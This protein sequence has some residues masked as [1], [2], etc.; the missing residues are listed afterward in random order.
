MHQDN[1]YDAYGA[2]AHIQEILQ[3]TEEQTRELQRKDAAALVAMSNND[4]QVEPNTDE[5]RQ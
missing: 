2:A 5:I 4:E 1:V 3:V